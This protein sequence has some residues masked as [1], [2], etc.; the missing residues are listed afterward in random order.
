MYIVNKENMSKCGVYA[1]ICTKNNK[2]YIGSTRNSFDERYAS[3]VQLL[4][5][6]NASFYLQLE[7]NKYGE[8]AF[9]FEIIKVC[10]SEHAYNEE[11]AE[12]DRTD[13][14]MLYNA[15]YKVAGASR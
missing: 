1:I 7:W 14:S 15:V 2:R 3:Q 5:N 8:Y 13:K 9:E 12:I 10:D 6:N 4:K 11:Q